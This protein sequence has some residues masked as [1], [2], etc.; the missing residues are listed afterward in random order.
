MG[1]CTAPRVGST[2]MSVVRLSVQDRRDT[3]L[4]NPKVPMIPHARRDQLDEVRVRRLRA[5]HDRAEVLP[6][7]RNGHP[8][9]LHV[10]RVGREAILGTELPVD[11][12][13]PTLPAPGRSRR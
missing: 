1:L 6:F 8:P 4:A 7:G 10:E 12:P 11:P 13:A 2:P 3:Y 9:H 5:V